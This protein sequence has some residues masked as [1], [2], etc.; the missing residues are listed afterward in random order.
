LVPKFLQEK[1]LYTDSGEPAFASTLETKEEPLLF[2]LNNEKQPSHESVESELIVE[3][4]AEKQK[5]PFDE[6]VLS[7]LTLIAYFDDPIFP[8]ALKEILNNKEN[9]QLLL[10]YEASL[11]SWTIVLAQY[12]YYRPWFRYAVKY[13]IFVISLI[14]MIIGFYDL[15]RNV[16]IVR[17]ILK[18]NMNGCVSWLEHLFLSLPLT[19]FVAYTS[20]FNQIFTYFMKP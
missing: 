12:G 9:K 7:D 19:F 20:S 14:T 10:L 8:F 17:K 3:E 15:Y 1:L 18:E 5:E 16:P 6:R 2:N 13:C 11:P 4:F